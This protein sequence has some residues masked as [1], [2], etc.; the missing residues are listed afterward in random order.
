MITFSGGKSFQKFQ[1]IFS[2]KPWLSNI[3]VFIDVLI[4]NLHTI[5]LFLLN[6]SKS[7]HIS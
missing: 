6:I 4:V 1:K 7:L 5:Y 3:Q 2:V